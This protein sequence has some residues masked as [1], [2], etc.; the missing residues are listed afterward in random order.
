MQRWCKWHTT[1]TNDA[2]WQNQEAVQRNSWRFTSDDCKGAE[3]IPENWLQEIKQN[4]GK[5]DNY[6][7]YKQ[8]DKIIVFTN[9]VNEDLLSSS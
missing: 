2:E 6:W 8:D 1:N 4:T 9:E 3:T 7:E 5:S